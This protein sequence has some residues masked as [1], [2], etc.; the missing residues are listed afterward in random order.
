MVGETTT[1]AD[2]LAAAIGEETA[3][4]FAARAGIPDATVRKYL[5][6]TVPGVDN[7]ILL[8]DTAGVRLEWL[9]ADRGPMR[10]DVTAEVAPAGPSALGE[11]KVRIERLAIEASAGGGLIALHENT[12]D[13]AEVPERWMRM[14]GVNP[15]YARI[16]TVR[17]DSNEP[18]IRDG[19]TLL[20]DISINQ[21]VDERFYI[22]VFSG[23]VL[24][25]R[26]QLDM[27]AGG[28][29]LLSDNDAYEPQS[30]A[31]KDLPDLHIAG[32]VAFYG[33]SI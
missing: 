13:T 32:R 6:G 31:A 23:I 21:I 20:V 12:V 16:L 18:T 30:I 26:V 27:G 33:R 11:G 2:R 22:V 28:I 3:Y 19:D 14:L 10:G 8:A 15:A 29:K 5:R 25:K 17:G 24:V 1:F 9:A 7:L 4:A